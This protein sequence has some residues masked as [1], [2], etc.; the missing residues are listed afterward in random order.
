MRIVDRKAFLAMP[1]GTVYAKYQPSVFEGLCIKGD[2]LFDSEGKA[3]DWFYQ[4][5]VDSIQAYDSG[6][7]GQ[8]LD[9]SQETGKELEMNFHFEGRDGCFE[10][11]QLFAVWSARDVLKLV[12]RLRQCL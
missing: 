7:W 2:T 9:E 6:E 3:I 8:L 10:D 1:A 12:D 4:Q 5:I 11:D